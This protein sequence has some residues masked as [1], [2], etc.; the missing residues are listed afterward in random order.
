[1]HVFKLLQHRRDVQGLESLF[2]AIPAGLEN[3]APTADV[4]GAQANSTSCAGASSRP[5][6]GEV[7]QEQG[8]L[9][10]GAPGDVTAA[11]AGEPNHMSA[12]GSVLA[13][14]RHRHSTVLQGG[15]AHYSRANMAQRS[16]LRWV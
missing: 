6:L 8:D 10:H 9:W 15:Q 7:R 2:A 1:M 13:R 3:C 5:V 4:L 12:G 11:T 16:P 14:T